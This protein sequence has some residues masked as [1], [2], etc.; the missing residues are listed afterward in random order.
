MEQFKNLKEQEVTSNLAVIKVII[1]LGNPGKQYENNR[2]SI[3]FKVLDVLAERYDGVWRSAPSALV[4]DITR[5]TKKILLVKPQT[6]MNSSG[7]ALPSLLKQGIKA[8]NILVVHD[9][10]EKPF[11]ALMIKQGGS[12]KGHNG[13]KSIISV[14]GLDFWRLRFGI[15]RPEHKEE[16]PVYVLQDFSESPALVQETIDRAVDQ[17]VRLVG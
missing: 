5:N 10:L 16:V 7:K 14:C 17:A 1:G 6:F 8:E 2:H 15:G 3:G 9:E 13:L 12:H 4:A 11:G